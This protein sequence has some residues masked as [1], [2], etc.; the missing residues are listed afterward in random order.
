[1]NAPLTDISPQYLDLERLVQIHM[2][3]AARLS[4]IREA[5]HVSVERLSAACGVPVERIELLEEGD[6]SRFDDILRVSMALSVSV[7]ITPW[8]EVT[9]NPA[10]SAVSYRVREPEYF[11][12]ASTVVSGSGQR[13]S[14]PQ[15][16]QT[17]AHCGS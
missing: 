15:K 8:S 1:M 7:S 12:G 9:V 14:D 17:L 2:D 13:Q 10:R 5:K 6:T 16:T 11:S 3:L 4:E